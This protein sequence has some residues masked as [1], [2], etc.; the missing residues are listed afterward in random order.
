MFTVV[1]QT[2]MLRSKMWDLFCGTQLWIPSGCG[3]TT[4]KV[5]K[6]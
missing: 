3:S 2:Q 4:G 5:R 6:G 1:L